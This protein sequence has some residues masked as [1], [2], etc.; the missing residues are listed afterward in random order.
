MSQNT[1][2]TNNFIFSP[3]SDV[4]FL[5]WNPFILFFWNNFDLCLYNYFKISNIGLL[6]LHPNMGHLKIGLN[7]GDK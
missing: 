7:I 5:E 3:I 1:S 2:K 6:K 4:P